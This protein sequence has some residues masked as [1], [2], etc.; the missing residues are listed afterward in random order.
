MNVTCMNHTI[1]LEF[2][3]RRVF[4]G[5]QLIGANRNGV[6]RFGDRATPSGQQMGNLGGYFMNTPAAAA[7]QPMTASSTATISRA[8]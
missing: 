6:A 7:T 8:W 4:R 2:W 5:C 3:E 1:F